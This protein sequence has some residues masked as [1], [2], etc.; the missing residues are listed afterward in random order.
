MTPSPTATA[1][2]PTATPTATATPSR[3]PTASPTATPLPPAATPTHTPTPSPTATPGDLWLG[4]EDLR[5]HPDGDL[6]YS[7]DLISFQVFA[8][9]GY[10]WESSDPPDVDLEIWLGAPQQ[11]YLVGADQ[12]AF[13]GGRDGEA[14]L[15]W[16]WDTAGLVG[17]QTLSALLDPDDEVQIGD[18]NP[19][20]NLITRTLTLQPAD[21]LPS[22]WADARWELQESGCCVFHY[23][24]G[25]AAA[26]DIDA[27][28]ALADEEIAYAST[29]LGE[30]VDRLALDVYLI[31][32]VLGHGGF[33]GEGVII[34]YLD[35]FYAGGD[36]GLVFRHE[37]THLIDQR[38]ARV[39]PTLMSEG[40]AVF[41]SGGHFR[42]EPLTERAAALLVLDRYIPLTELA[43]A[44]YPSQHEIGYLEAAGFVSFLVEHFGWE[45][46]KAFYGDMQADEAGQAAMIDAALQDHFGLSLT[47]AEADWLAA[48]EAMSVSP[49]QVA[50]L[51]L[52]IDYY[53]TVRDYQRA[54]DRSAYFLG[55]WLPSLQEAEKRNI[56]AD[57]MRHPDRWINVTLETMFI[58]A[59]QA[60]DAGAY[61]RVEA[62]LTAIKAV[63]AAD[64]DLNAD[65][66]ADQYGEVVRSTSLAG[67]EAQQVSL[68]PE[69]GE[70]RIVATERYTAV[71]VELYFARRAGTWRLLTGN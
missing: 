33:A 59:D 10:D 21:Q 60:L 1:I 4:P 24:A 38:F 63:L 54:W 58:A 61:D 31:D 16:V 41:V 12:I 40:L 48:L 71:L 6:V 5:V 11:G 20:N 47:Q 52:T 25:S 29:Q 37:A 43:D 7:G 27:M 68:D 9:H 51:R 46:F 18:E 66:L 30:E 28:M 36:L 50:D 22:V 67:Y 13:Y 8:H 19:D 42:E 53:D 23:I 57:W 49:D 15:E 55:A 34:S 39:R 65:A 32:R 2:P 56:T 3:T 44:F 45:A 70:A 17:P 14:R 64:G 26:R 35:R 69:R 62:L